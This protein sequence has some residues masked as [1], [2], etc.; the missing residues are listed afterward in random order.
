MQPLLLFWM[1]RPG[2]TDHGSTP[3]LYHFPRIC[4][5]MSTDHRQAAFFPSLKAMADAMNVPR[6]LQSVTAENIVEFVENFLRHPED[7]LVKTEIF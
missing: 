5:V 7:L 1:I 4:I 2:S 3:P 6:L